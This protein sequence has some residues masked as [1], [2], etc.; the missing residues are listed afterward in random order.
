MVSSKTQPAMRVC[1][2]MDYITINH[3]C[4]LLILRVVHISMST[5]TKSYSISRPWFLGSWLW[6]ESCWPI[7]VTF[8]LRQ[9]CVSWLF[10]LY[11]FS[12]WVILPL[13]LLSKK[14]F[15]N[16]Y[17]FCSISVASSLM[18]LQA[19]SS[20]GAGLPLTTSTQVQS[21]DVREFLLMPQDYNQGSIM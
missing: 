1:I 2:F 9:F 3:V 19:G 11:H 4:T 7:V 16:I 21:L 18:T 6:P 20:A 13:L 17:V 15:F 14:P 12:N 10:P 5:T 8:V